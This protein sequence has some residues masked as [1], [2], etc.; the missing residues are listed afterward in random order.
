M[1]LETLVASIARNE[2]LFATLAVVVVWAGIMIF[3]VLVLRIFKIGLKILIVGMFAVVVLILVLQVASI[4]DSIPR[5]MAAI[6]NSTISGSLESVTAAWSRA[7]LAYQSLP[8]ASQ[9]S[10]PPNASPVL[11]QKRTKPA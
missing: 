2:F 10:P 4:A 11:P 6:K 7:Q 5:V 8:W 3:A 9:L 1:T